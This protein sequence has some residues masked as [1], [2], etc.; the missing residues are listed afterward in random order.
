MALHLTADH[1]LGHPGILKSCARPFAS[2]EE[3]DQA[4]VRA[5]NET[6][7][8]GDDVLHLGDFAWK[9]GR[10]R[11]TA[12]FERLNGNKWLL[13]GNHDHKLVRSLPWKGLLPPIHQVEVDGETLVLSHYPLRSWNRSRYGA[14][15]LYGHVHGRIQATRQSIDVGVDAWDYR[16]VPL[17]RLLAVMNSFPP[18]AYPDENP[19]IIGY[20][21]LADELEASAPSGPAR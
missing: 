1:H 5:W 16:P 20:A 12:L 13:P 10:T 21:A 19:P 17:P 4:L 18:I 2:V 7:A 8:P 14:R 3:M 11:M 6:V 15:N 9:I